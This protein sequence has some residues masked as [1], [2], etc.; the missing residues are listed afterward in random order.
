[1]TLA[2]LVA[3][4]LPGGNR[5]AITWSSDG[6]SDGDRVVVVRRAVAYPEDPEPETASQGVVIAGATPI[7]KSPA[8]VCRVVD[9][10]LFDG[11]TYY[12]RAF[13]YREGG[14]GREYDLGQAYLASATATGPYEFG[15]RMYRLVP[16]IHRRFDTGGRLRSFLGL[17]GGQLDQTYSAVRG[18]PGLVDVDTV[19]GR[20]L[21]LLGDWI[22]WRLDHSR[23]FDRQRFE[24]RGAVPLYRATQT[25][26]AVQAGVRRV[27]GWDST[28]REFADN[29]ATTNRPERHNIWLLSPGEAAV[30]DPG[31]Q[32]VSLDEASADRVCV[33][34]GDDMLRMFY[35]T[36]RSG[37]TAIRHKRL[38]KTGWQASAV[39]VS[40]RG[41]EREPV[42]VRRAATLWLFWAA[43]RPDAGWRIEFRRQIDGGSWSEVIPFVVD[44]QDSVQRRSPAVLVDDDNGLWVFWRE[45]AGDRWTLRY[46]RF[47]G[48]EPVLSPAAAMTFPLDGRAD[49]RV[50]TDLSVSLL[51]AAAGQPGPR[52]SVL[53]ARRE[54]LN[55]D[56][57]GQRAWRV[58]ARFKLSTDVSK[59][60]D[61]SSVVELP[62]LPGAHDREPFAFQTGGGPLIAYLSST[63]D[64]SWSIWRS[65]LDPA[66]RTWGPPSPVTG[67]PYS[68]RAPV[69]F[70]I[71]QEVRLAYR[72]ARP[73]VYRSARS[74]SSVTVDVRYC[75]STTLRAGNGGQVALMGGPAD[76]TAYTSDAGPP[77]GRTDADLIARDTLGVYVDTTG[78]DAV[79]VDS[80]RRRLVEVMG[81]FLP[82]TTRAVVIPTKDG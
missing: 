49:P 34:A 8:G 77:G 23:G 21:P 15:D 75:G 13:P 65:T 54:P 63:R 9:G 48:A 35:A 47:S 56:G 62:G 76:F 40:G 74:A 51:S 17:V 12:Y 71:G 10:E 16:E 7:E 45:L 70:Q 2:E 6:D 39:V 60:D 69:A 68:D 1:V 79:D 57:S 58:G 72:S 3:A 50:E 64:G 27:T 5:I 61:W 30:A 43:R 14:N 36:N 31:D 11:T 4:P 24:L 52:I 37:Q 80:G 26:A 59:V 33:D 53:W 32:P 29:V 78:V 28:Y 67:P 25:L 82:V 20:L 46:Q 55:Q 44:D 42:A 19:D 81:E 18:I 73:V 22:G 66:T 41:T 38:G